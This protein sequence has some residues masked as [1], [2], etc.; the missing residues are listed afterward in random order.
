LSGDRLDLNSKDGADMSAYGLTRNENVEILV[1]TALEYGVTD[2]RQIAYILA[3]AQHE[4]DNFRTA[5]EYDGRGQALRLGYSG[6]ADYY[7]RGYVQVTHDHRYD[8]MAEVLG[9]PRISRDPDIVARD[10]RIGGQTTVVGMVRGL[11][12]GVGLDQFINDHRKDYVGARAVVNGSD[13]ATRIAGYAE[14]WEQ[15]VQ[16]V[17]ERVT[18]DGIVPRLMPGSPMSDGALRRGE[19]GPEVRRLQ[20]ALVRDGA[21]MKPD[22]NFGRGTK[23]EVEAWQRRHDMPATG[24]ADRDMLKALGVEPQQGRAGV[25]GRQSNL[26]HRPEDADHVDHALQQKLR[27]QV[28]NLDQQAGKPWDDASERLAA[29]ALVMA[30][31]IGFT[32]RDDLQ[33]AFNRPSERHA[34][35]EVLH[36]MRQGA[37][38]SPDPGANRAHMSTADALA[39]PAH[40][41][42]RQVEA[43]SHHQAHPQPERSQQAQEQNVQVRSGPV[44]Q[45]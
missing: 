45:V 1:R 21:V 15:S 29:S 9:D 26:S 31:E 22:G 19:M 6:G 3:T 7:G 27:E 42:L 2:T 40:E 33:L 24:V 8:R 41:R 38:M 17:V 36:L 10:P 43:I 35:G 34:G 25:P 37:G 11:Y 13:Q 14:A 30:K 44:M 18:R 4:S 32:A 12:T 20:E 5:R 23:A 16:G 39:L 28:R